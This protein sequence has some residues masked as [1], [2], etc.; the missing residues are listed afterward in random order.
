MARHNEDVRTLRAAAA[1]AVD[2][3]NAA[4]L[5]RTADDLV[6]RRRVVNL[7]ETV[8]Y[9]RLIARLNDR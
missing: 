6:A 2:P 8:L 7:D 4:Y 5:A 3:E 9:A 1:V